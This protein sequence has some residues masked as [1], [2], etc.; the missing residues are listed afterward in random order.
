MQYNF[1]KTFDGQEEEVKDY[2]ISQCQVPT[3]EEFEPAGVSQRVIYQEY[4]VDDYKVKKNYIYLNPAESE[5][6]GL[7]K[8]EHYEVVSS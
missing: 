1:E 8:F 5:S 4:L 7:I 6:N 3:Y 2:F